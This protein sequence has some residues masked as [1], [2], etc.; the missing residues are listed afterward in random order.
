MSCFSGCLGAHGHGRG[1][2][3]VGEGEVGFADGAVG[4]VG[5]GG[6]FEAVGEEEALEGEAGGP[7]ILERHY[8]FGL[9]HEEFALGGEN[10]G[11]GGEHEAVFFDEER[12]GLFR[13]RKNF[14][15]VFE[16][17]LAGA[18]VFVDGGGGTLAKR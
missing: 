18:G 8:V 7:E 4:V 15:A 3:A 17:G 2:E 10:V 9:Q 16:G 11:I 5:V 12:V 14:V 13:A 6:G 1:H